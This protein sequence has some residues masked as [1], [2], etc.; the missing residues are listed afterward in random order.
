MSFKEEIY[1]LP[2]L[3]EGVNKSDPFYDND[4]TEKDLRL[5]WDEIYRIMSSIV[6]ERINDN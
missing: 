1:R 4:L 6:K 3:I 5:K 2:E